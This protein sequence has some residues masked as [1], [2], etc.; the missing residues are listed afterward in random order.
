[1]VGTQL[2]ALVDVL[3]AGDAVG[4]DAHCLINH[5]DEDAVDHE[6]GSFLHLHGLFAD[7]SGELYDALG[8]L[9]AGELT[10]DDFNQCH[11]VGG[12]EE[13]HADELCRTTGAS[14]NLCDGERRR[15]GGEDGLGLA[16]LVKLR[17]HILLQ[18]HVLH[19]GLDDEVGIGERGV[20]GRGG[21]VCQDGIH[22]LL[23][24]FSLLNELVVTL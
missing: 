15:V 19:S 24:D 9:V 4:Q 5:G 11:A 23:S 17:E 13:V 22:R 20:V 14:G 3:G 8:H 1:M 10:L 6:A 7:G 18:L 12:V 21:D 2:H 16:D